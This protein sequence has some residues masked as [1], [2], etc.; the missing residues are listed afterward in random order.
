MRGWWPCTAMSQSC[1]PNE[2]G[3]TATKKTLYSYP[4]RQRLR[5]V[6]FK[7]AQCPNTV[8]HD[9]CGGVSS[10]LVGE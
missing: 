7:K 5:Q 2:A 9:S 8:R 4:A 3:T 1:C 6:A 10:P